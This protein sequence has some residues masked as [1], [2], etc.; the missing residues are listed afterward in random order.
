MPTK[1]K[2]RKRITCLK[3]DK[4]FEVV[5]N[6]QNRYRKICDNCREQNKSIYDFNGMGF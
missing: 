4:E 2:R 1:R 3:C 6:R 5:L